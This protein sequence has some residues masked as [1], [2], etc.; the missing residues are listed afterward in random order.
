MLSGGERHFVQ[1]AGEPVLDV[2]GRVRLDPLVEHR[3]VVEA[4]D[5]GNRGDEAQ[6]DSIELHGADRSEL[7]HSVQ[8]LLDLFRGG[9]RYHQDQIPSP[10]AVG[11][12]SHSGGVSHVKARIA[13]THAS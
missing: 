13:T 11:S 8:R 10:N 4:R 2:G 6:R 1:V 9:A 5:E 7:A 3:L 12:R